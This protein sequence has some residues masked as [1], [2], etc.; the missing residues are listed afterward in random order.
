M[1]NHLLYKSYNPNFPP[2]CHRYELAEKLGTPGTCCL[3]VYLK[4]VKTRNNYGYGSMFGVPFILQVPR[5]G[6][7]YD[8]LYQ[9]IIA[10]MKRYLRIP[11]EQDKFSA[12][13]DASNLP[14]NNPSGCDSEMDTEETEMST[15]VANGNEIRPME[16]NGIEHVPSSVQPKRLFSM[17]LVNLSGNTSLGRLKQNGK[18][19]TFAG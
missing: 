6:L 13:E 11:P 9:L 15:D 8:Q 16:T 1:F 10:R 18:T 12:T 14:V 3:S 17:D 19:I 2:M 4:E 7:D 5:E